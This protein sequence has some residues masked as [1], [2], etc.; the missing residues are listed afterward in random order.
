MTLVI[1]EFSPV[2]DN[3]IAS[4]DYFATLCRRNRPHYCQIVLQGNGLHPSERLPPFQEDR[5][6]VHGESHG[7]EFWENKDICSSALHITLHQP[8]EPAA[9]LP[10]SLPQNI[11]LAQNYIK[12]SPSH[13]HYF[14]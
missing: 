9:I 3:K 11:A 5:I 7:E 4:V 12:I 14:L 10:W 13:S 1:V 2:R 8:G 6:V